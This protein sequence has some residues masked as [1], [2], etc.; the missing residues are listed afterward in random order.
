MKLFGIGSECNSSSRVAMV[1]M[2]TA[3]ASMLAFAMVGGAQSEGLPTTLTGRDALTH[4]AGKAVVEAAKLLEA[5]KLAEVKRR[6]VKEVRDEWAALPAAEQREEI[7][8]ARERAPDPGAFEADIARIG[9]LTIYGDSASL[10]IPTPDGG[11]AAMAFV[12]LEGGQWKV[13]GGPMT[14]EPEPAETAPPIAGAAILEHPIGALA[15]DYAKRLQADKIE[16]ALELLSG[17]ARAKRAAESAAER[18]ASDEFR[19][20]H[21]PSAATLA[22]QIRSGGRLSF[23][24]EQA[25]LNVITN[26][27]TK[28][29]DGSTSYSST[30][31][32]LPFALQN[33]EWR[34]AD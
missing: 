13:T 11:V 4:P 25:Y 20:Q 24:G 29:P 23:V 28:N 21:L 26:V 32:Q 30:S 16:S 12:S 3:V 5:G 33:G 22:E 1:A 17:P 9:E 2:T 7:A 19:R 27:T 10:R 31:T 15:I 8:R 34:I 18:K 14:F 6:S